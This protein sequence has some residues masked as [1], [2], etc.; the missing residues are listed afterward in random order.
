[1]VTLY[2]RYCQ[3]R[4]D[5]GYEAGFGIRQHVW[6]ACDLEAQQ[7]MVAQMEKG[8]KQVADA[9]LKKAEYDKRYGEVW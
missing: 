2:E 6:D 4:I 7:S 3:A 8:A 1:M 9:K 5:C